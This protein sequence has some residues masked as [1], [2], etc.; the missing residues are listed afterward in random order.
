MTDTPTTPLAP[1]DD[2]APGQPGTGEDLCPHCGGS[3]TMGDGAECAV[4]AGTGKVIRGVGG[5]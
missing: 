4:C 5:G 2:A 1:G 3:G